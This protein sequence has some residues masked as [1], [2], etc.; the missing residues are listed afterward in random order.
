[1]IVN[2]DKTVSMKKKKPIK[3]EGDP[4]EADNLRADLKRRKIIDCFLSA[5][6][7]SIWPS[8]N[9]PLIKAKPNFSIFI[10]LLLYTVLF[11]L[12]VSSMGRTYLTIARTICH[13]FEIY[14]VSR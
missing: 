10:S 14:V 5:I 12:I 11:F 9:R 4:V 1:M 6:A 13:E 2:C 8:F 3:L 7:I